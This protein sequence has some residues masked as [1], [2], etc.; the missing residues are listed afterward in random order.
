MSEELYL[1]LDVG[2]SSSK[3][4]AFD[5]RGRAVA[6]GSAPTPWSD[7]QGV[8]ELAPAA[9]LDAV[10]TA[11]RQVL[12]GLT[13][14][15]IAGLGVA[16]FAE[17]G[18]LLDRHGSPL[19]P[20]VPW[21]DTRDAA[22]LTAL[23][24]EIGANR[25]SAATGL[26]LWQQWS[27]TKHRWLR[28][29]RPE[30]RDAVRRLNVAEWVVHALGGEPAS[31]QSLASRT[32]WLRLAERTWWDETL[33]WSGLP[34]G[35]LPPLVTAGT[36]L[37][38]VS[39]DA[40]LPELTGAV[41]TVAG[42]D[43]QAAAIGVG[44]A[45]PGD[46]LDSCG[47]AEALVRSV[48][49]GLPPDVVTQLT[50]GGI[51]V[52]WHAAGDTWCLLGGTQGGLTLRRVLRLLGRGGDLPALDREALARPPSSFRVVAPPFGRLDVLDLADADPADVWRA[53]LEEVTAQAGA[54]HDRMTAASGP[55]RELV[56]TGG[57]AHSQGL[58]AVKR[59]RLGPLRLPE[60]AEAG[61]RGAASLAARAA[62][63][64]PLAEPGRTP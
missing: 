64:A 38:R 12:T 41:L 3:V 28:T 15:S 32:G 13:P 22:E 52:G 33:E 20:I 48:P 47:T 45:G 10:R 39:T 57:W 36:A 26:P 56:V 25:F 34:V 61:A 62:G 37:G 27:L 60:V 63:H 35:A 4:V 2:T 40:G 14:G 59:E 49:P 23:G 46:E 30:T 51:T 58:L 11:L 55:H 19:G 43:H 53:A 17:S 8:A 16:S 5:A 50:E 21:H 54:V 6:S 29:H 9:L 31:E 42:H 1:G 18:V 7:A 24:A 44:A